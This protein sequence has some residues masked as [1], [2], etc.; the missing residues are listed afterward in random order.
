LSVVLCDVTDIPAIEID[1][2]VS[3]V[4]LILDIAGCCA[5][6]DGLN[7][8]RQPLLRDHKAMISIADAICTTEQ[9]QPPRLLHNV[10]ETIMVLR[11]REGDPSI[12]GVPN[13]PYPRSRMC[14]IEIKHARDL[15]V[16]DNTVVRGEVAVANHL[17]RKAWR[18]EPIAVL[19]M[20]E[21]DRR[22]MKLSEQP[23]CTHQGPVGPETVRKGIIADLAW[24]ESQSLGRSG[25]IPGDDL[26]STDKPSVPN[27][28]EHG[29][30]YRRVRAARSNNSIASLG[31]LIEVALHQIRA[32]GSH[33]HSII[34]SPCHSPRSLTAPSII[35]RPRVRAIRH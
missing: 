13:V 15:T 24:Q 26:R 16:D 27:V 4:L 30:D 22:I 34:A 21:A 1:V 2:T 23:S 11:S 14:S 3:D 29:M 31:H 6:F 9:P 10:S 20:L 5:G 33:H 28:S 35:E 17:D 12:R 19:A 25:R 18:Q 8:K 7:K 32:F